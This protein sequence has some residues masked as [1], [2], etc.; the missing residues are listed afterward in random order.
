MRHEIRGTPADAAS[1]GYTRGMEHDPKK[2]YRHLIVALIVGTILVSVMYWYAFVSGAGEKEFRR[3]HEA[4]AKAQSWKMRYGTARPRMRSVLEAEVS[5]TGGIHLSRSMEFI[6]NPA[7]NYTQ[8]VAFAD[9][10][11]YYTEQR[12]G[13]WRPGAG[14]DSEFVYVCMLKDRGDDA[15][16][17]PPFKHFIQSMSIAKGEKKV[18][19]GVECRVWHARHPI[20]AAAELNEDVCLDEQHLPRERV[21][22]GGVYTY[23][24]WNMP[25]TVKRPL[26]IAAEE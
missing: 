14:Y 18:V 2:V 19:N 10:A 9:G 24:D 3:A 7:N 15:P 20:K 5:C 22:D 1:G 8:E 6:N 26:V 25:I 23:W 13:E 12:T 4:V 17:L 16:P 21:V 11:W